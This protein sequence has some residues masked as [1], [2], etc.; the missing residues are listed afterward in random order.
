MF[1]ASCVDLEPFRPAFVGE[2][3][4]VVQSVYKE[5]GRL[6]TPKRPLLFRWRKI[7]PYL[8]QELRKSARAFVED[9]ASHRLQCST[10]I[11]P[12]CRLCGT[13]VQFFSLS[14]PFTKNI[15][16]G[17]CATRPN[18]KHCCMLMPCTNQILP[19]DFPIAIVRLMINRK[20]DQSD[21]RKSGAH[22]P[23]KSRT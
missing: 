7:T 8:Y 18:F 23:I 11:S 14:D 21:S 3:P 15:D 20:V 16:I 12:T 19:N 4:V 5:K 10:K 9:W 2:L 13:E 1:C 17:N 6:H 22:G